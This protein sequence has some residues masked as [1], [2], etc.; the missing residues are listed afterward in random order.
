M[1]DIFSED[2]DLVV[3]FT[4]TYDTSSDDA[5]IISPRSVQGQL[6]QKIYGGDSQALD[7]ALQDSLYGVSQLSTESRP[8][9]PRG[10]LVRYPIGTVAVLSKGSTRYYCVAY[11]KMSNALVARSSVDDL[12]A[13]LRSAWSVIAV[14]GHSNSIAMPIVGSELARVDNLGRESLLKMIL[15]S[16]VAKSREGLISRSLTV[17]IHPKDADQIDMNEVQ[18]FLRSV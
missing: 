8:E 4:D 2:A 17:V 11:S 18:A 6:L 5:S 10:K 16:F 13:S 1:G 9:K 15:L 7:S 3:G 14:H 12:W